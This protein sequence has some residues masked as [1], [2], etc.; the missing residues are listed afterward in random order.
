MAK[1]FET[2]TPQIQEFIHA[3]H[4]FFVATAPLSES[5]HVNIS[6]KG[7]ESFHILS[8]TQVAYMDLTGSGNETSA[9]VTENG[10]ITIMFC[11][12]DG[13]PNIVRLFGKG[14]TILPKDAEWDSLI[15]HFTPQLSTRQ[16]IVV[17]VHM[18]QTS[19]GYAVPFMDFVGER[20]TLT[21]FA[22][23]KGEEG[24]VEYRR[25]KNSFSIDK[26]PTPLGQCLSEA[27]EQIK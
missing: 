6:P 21:K 23:A 3:Q 2:L 27:A 26:L 13:P 8:E 11:A 15:T 12:F 22:E 17:D 24:I 19:C 18:T 10:R 1:F 16:I 4:M 7:L 9:H 14:R 25:Q 20:D 5:G